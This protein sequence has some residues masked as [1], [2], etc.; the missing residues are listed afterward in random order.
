MGPFVMLLCAIGAFYVGL[1]PYPLYV[2]L[3]IGAVWC[4][5]Y[6]LYHPRIIAAAEGKVFGYL[7]RSWIFNCVQCL[8]LYGLGY[9]V[10]SLLA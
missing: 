5:G 7:F 1:S 9:G 8:A 6:I 3:P 10:R 2:L 4:V